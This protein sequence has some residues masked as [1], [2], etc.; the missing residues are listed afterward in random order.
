[1][2]RLQCIRAIGRSSK[3]YFKPYS[4]PICVQH[5][6]VNRLDFKFYFPSIIRRYSTNRNRH[7]I[8]GIVIKETS[9]LN[10]VKI[11]SY[12]DNWYTFHVS[13]I[14]IFLRLYARYVEI[15]ND[16]F[17]RTVMKI[18][19]LRKYLKAT[20]SADCIFACMSWAGFV[21]IFPDICTYTSMFAHVS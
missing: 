1:M 12:I 16:R 8:C 21:H 13:H 11:F 6:G 5:V 19:S 17:E 4:W 7:S 14:L 18:R 20:R 10:S 9:A 3:D 2:L 15:N